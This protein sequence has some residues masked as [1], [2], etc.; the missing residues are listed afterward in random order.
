MDELRRTDWDKIGKHQARKGPEY[1]T[2]YLYRCEIHYPVLI[3]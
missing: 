2:K 3:R 1:V